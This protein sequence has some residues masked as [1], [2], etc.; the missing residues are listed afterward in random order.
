MDGN[1]HRAVI[2]SWIDSNIDGGIDR[3]NDLHVDQI[4]TAWISKRSWTAAAL[5]SFELA[6]DIRNSHYK[7]SHLNVLLSIPLLSGEE[8]LGMTFH[9][10]EDLEGSLSYIPP[11]LYLLRSDNK[12]VREAKAAKERGVDGGSNLRVLSGSKLLGDL[13]VAF[14]CLYSESKRYGEDEYS[15]YLYLVG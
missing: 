7:A 4:D 11:S 12:I 2:T 14:T 5:E 1:R 15:R 8:P 3:L 6:V 13:R 9:S 10:R